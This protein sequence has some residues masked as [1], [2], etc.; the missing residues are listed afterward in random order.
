M[1]LQARTCAPP[2]VSRYPAAGV[3]PEG[4]G[5]RPESSWPLRYRLANSLDSACGS[6][7]VIGC[8]L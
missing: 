2:A 7:E 1:K 8:G 5:R 6:H 3:P 4:A